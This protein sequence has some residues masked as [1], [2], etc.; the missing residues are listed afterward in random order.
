ML[1]EGF[2]G[3]VCDFVIHEA[4]KWGA[5]VIVLGTHGW[6]GVG[7]VLMGSDAEQIVRSSPVLLV[8]GRSRYRSWTTVPWWYKAFQPWAARRHRVARRVT[9]S[10]WTSV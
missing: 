7:H 4:Q 9:R 10:P 2:A 1:C 3:R 8:R 6:R 5:E